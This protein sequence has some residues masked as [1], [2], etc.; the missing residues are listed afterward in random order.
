MFLGLFLAYPTVGVTVT[1]GGTAAFVTSV[2][3]V[4]ECVFVTCITLLAFIDIGAT[5]PVVCDLARSFVTCVTFAVEATDEVYTVRVPRAVIDLS[6]AFVHV[7]LA[8][9]SFK[10]SRT[11]ALARQLTLTAIL[12]GWVALRY[13]SI[14]VAD[15]SVS[16]NAGEAINIIHTIGI[17]GAIMA[18][19]RAFI[20]SDAVSFGASR[21]SR[22]TFAPVRSGHVDT[23]RGILVAVHCCARSVEA[24]V[25]I[26]AGVPDLPIPAGADAF[27]VR[28]VGQ[29][30]LWCR[31][32]TLST[33]E[34]VALT[35]LA[36]ATRDGEP[37]RWRT[38]RSG[39]D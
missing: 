3:I 25:D 24:F 23:D 5:L 39:A 36:A 28:G 17:R 12:T 4:A 2:Q 31:T 1:T 27:V 18:S 33:A 34:V 21:V 6:F 37:L 11:V 35:E 26:L 29:T 10:A 22:K 14:S 8:L 20:D 19:L 32:Q 15:E 9:L 30:D 16:T 38:V 7:I 13:T